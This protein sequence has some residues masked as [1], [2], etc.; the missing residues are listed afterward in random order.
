MRNAGH[1]MWSYCRVSRS[2]ALPCLATSRT[3]PG[4]AGGGGDMPIAT[5]SPRLC[6]FPSLALNFPS[7]KW[8]HKEIHP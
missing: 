3:N 2:W 4:E 5:L 8:A 6:P 7:I 1:S